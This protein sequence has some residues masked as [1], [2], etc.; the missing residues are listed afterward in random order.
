MRLSPSSLSVIG[1]VAL[2]AAAANVKTGASQSNK[3]TGPVATRERELKRRTLVINDSNIDQVQEVHVAPGVPTTI[4]F[5]VAIKPGKAQVL[6]ADTNGSFDSAPMQMEKA[7][8]LAPRQGLADIPKTPLTV[9]LSDG[10]TLAFQV[11]SVPDEVDLQ[12]EVQLDLQRRAAPMSAAALQGSNEQLRAQLDECR[13]SAGN[14]GISKVASLI[15]EQDIDK[16]E[17]FTVERHDLRYLDKQ[18]RLLVQVRQAYRLFGLTYVVVTVENRDPDKS[19][20]LDRAEVKVIGGEA[21]TDAEVIEAV[22][23]LASLPPDEVEK[24]VVA[25]KTPE[26]A[27]G[28]KLNLSLFEKNGNRAVQLEGIHL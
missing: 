22:P 17:A 1:L 28:A 3:V 27:T 5:P 26:Q 6:L 7:I 8:V 13:A 20:V 10:T 24:I 19:W 25:F 21:T 2:S 11:M 4:L 18:S 15:I 16:P 9:A 23:E 14:A 12:L